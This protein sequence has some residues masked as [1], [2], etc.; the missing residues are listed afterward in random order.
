MWV[1]S[2]PVVVNLFIDDRTSAHVTGL[3]LAVSYAAR[4]A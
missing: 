1:I 2:V 3:P 4:S